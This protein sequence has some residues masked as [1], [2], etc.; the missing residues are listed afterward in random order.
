MTDCR[1]VTT[2]ID[3]AERARAL[4]TAIVEE[5]LAACVQVLG[6]MESTFRWEGKAR[7][8][9][10]WLVVAKTTDARLQEL[11]ARIKALHSYQVPEIIAQPITAGEPAYL[12]SLR[13]QTTPSSGE[14]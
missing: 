5:R 11:M 12:G 7:R 4:A 6:P 10:E 14:D 9:S 3:S 8:E 13:A 1:Q 2:S